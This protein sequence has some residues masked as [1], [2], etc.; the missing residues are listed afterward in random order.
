MHSPLNH[1]CR[2]PQ[3]RLALLEMARVDQDM[4]KTLAQ[5]PAGFNP[6][7]DR[8]NTASLKKIVDQIGWPTRSEVGPDGAGAAWLLAQHA[9]LDPV[10]QEQ[11]LALMKAAPCGEV[12]PKNIAYLE[13]RV[14]VNKR[15]PQRFGTQC[16]IVEGVVKPFP[17]E[18]ET[19]VD[20]RRLAIGLPTM[21]EHL[22][23]MRSRS[24]S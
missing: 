3:I 2:N 15:K 8:A 9:D 1:I 10:F 24:A 22:L 4:R 12:D 18:D 16:C 6:D 17:I 21:A 7:I 19:R 5:D 11:A 13:D 20:E 14:L 23:R